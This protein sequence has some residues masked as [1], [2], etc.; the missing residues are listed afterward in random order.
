[1]LKSNFGLGGSKANTVAPRSIKEQE[2]LSFGGNTFL[3][4][5]SYSDI[6]LASNGWG[7]G[8]SKITCMDL[9]ATIGHIVTSSVL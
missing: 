5:I 2:I 4:R 8:C 6:T 9:D 7:L 3:K 1:M